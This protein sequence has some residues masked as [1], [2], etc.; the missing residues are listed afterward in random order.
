MYNLDSHI[1]KSM[2]SFLIKDWCMENLSPGE[3]W[4][5]LNLSDSE[6]Q[7]FDEEVW[8]NQ[9]SKYLSKKIEDQ[10]PG[11]SWPISELDWEEIAGRTHSGPGLAAVTDLDLLSPQ[12]DEAYSETLKF[13]Y[14]RGCPWIANNHYSHYNPSEWN[15]LND[16]LVRTFK[17]R[18]KFSENY[19]QL[20][21]GVSL[22]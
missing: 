15:E 17:K 20:L 5:Y 14:E 22:V 6:R 1:N 16:S 13:W 2:N 7:V 10:D 11:D 12:E 3:F 9:V 4:R 19:N 8:D 21:L 18:G